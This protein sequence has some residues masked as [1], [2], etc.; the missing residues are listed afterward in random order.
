MNEMF[1]TPAQNR[2][3]DGMSNILVPRSRD[4]ISFG[5]VVGET[6]GSGCSSFGMSSFSPVFG[7]TK[8]K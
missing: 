7:W 4:P 5:H 6:E 2:V 8:I 1:E 3:I